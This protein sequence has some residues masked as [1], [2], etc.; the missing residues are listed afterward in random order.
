MSII[1]LRT[2]YK[3]YFSKSI[4]SIDNIQFVSTENIQFVLNAA[5]FITLSL[6]YNCFP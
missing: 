4:N 6:P 1:I 5:I 2:L 3:L